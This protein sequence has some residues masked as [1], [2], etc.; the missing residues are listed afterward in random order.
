[1]KA[2]SKHLLNF[3]FVLSCS[4]IV[5]FFVALFGGAALVERISGKP[6]KM[7]IFHFLATG[8]PLA[9]LGTLAGTLGGRSQQKGFHL[10]TIGVTVIMALLFAVGAQLLF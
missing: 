9:I 5:T 10:R 4:F 2:V 8:T 6:V 7:D 1:M 3:L